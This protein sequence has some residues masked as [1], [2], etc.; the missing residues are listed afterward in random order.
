MDQKCS[1]D[2]EEHTSDCKRVWRKAFVE[3]KNNETIENVERS[4]EEENPSNSFFV[5]RKGRGRGSGRGREEV[6]ER[7]KRKK[8]NICFISSLNFKVFS[9]YIKKYKVS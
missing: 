1:N 2:G 9:L 3:K 8:H 7:E 4:E 5:E 6:R